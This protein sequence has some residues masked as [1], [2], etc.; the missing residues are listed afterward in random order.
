MG[1]VYRAL[2]RQSKRF[3]ALKILHPS[4]NA[5]P[6]YRDRFLR[7]MRALKTLAHP[8]IVPFLDAGEADQQAYLAMEFIDGVDL[9]VVIKSAGIF[10]RRLRW[11][12]CC[13]SLR[14]SDSLIPRDFSAW[15]SN[16]TTSR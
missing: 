2:D 11:R 6:N 9:K 14:P 15:I 10:D 12:Y 13:Q 3:V 7:E 5:D 4:L 8:N 1:T 16:L